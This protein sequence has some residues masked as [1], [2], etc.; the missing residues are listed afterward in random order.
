MSLP[1]QGVHRVL[2]VDTSL[3]CTGLGVVEAVGTRS[4]ML[5]C[6]LVKNK[7]ALPHSTCLLN[8]QRDVSVWIEKYK[9]TAVAIEGGFFFKNASTAMVLGEARG[10]VIA[11]A[12]GHDVPVFE[13]SPRKVKQSL[14]G[15]GSAQKSQVAEMVRRLLNLQEAPQEDSADALAIAICHLHA[16]GPHPQLRPEPI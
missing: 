14:V 16:F 6:G 9:P 4:R 13:Y 8:I 2:G 1:A 3:R 12:A 15:N 7:Q 10:V 11:C 5:E